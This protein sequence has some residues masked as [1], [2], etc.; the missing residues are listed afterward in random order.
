M[1]MII[2]AFH[3]EAK[4]AKMAH[5]KIS[6]TMQDTDCGQHTTDIKSIAFFDPIRG[7]FYQCRTA[8]GKKSF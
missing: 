7:I 5:Q 6:Q 3:L 1:K 8:R 4:M 2:V